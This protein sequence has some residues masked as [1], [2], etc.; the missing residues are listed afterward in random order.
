MK[1]IGMPI[2]IATAVLCAALQGC[3]DP[4]KVP[5][6]NG[7]APTAIPADG[8]TIAPVPVEPDP[9]NIDEPVAVK[10]IKPVKPVK[11]VKPAPAVKPVKPVAAPA[12]KPAAPLA[13]AP[14]ATT[15]VVKKGDM[16]SKI[17]KANKCR[18]EDIV[19]ANPGIRPDHIVPGQ[20][21]VIPAASAAPAKAAP[22]PA[23]KPAAAPA[24]K[25][26][27]PA[28]GAGEYVV[29]EGD[30]LSKIAKANGT[31]VGKIR[32]L[33]GLKGDMIRVGQKLKL[34][35]AGAAAAAPAPAAAAKP[36]DKNQAAAKP[37]EKPKKT[38]KPAPADAKPAEQPASKVDSVA[39]TV[40]EPPAD[41]GQY[42]LYTVLDGEDVFG[43]AVKFGVTT[44][45]IRSLNNLQDNTSLRA[46]QVLKLP[47]D[48]EAPG[49]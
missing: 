38:E 6:S 3:K 8:G 32:E 43:V 19:S 7:P 13:P 23:A 37:A 25:P 30:V 1:K 44:A 18:L 2:G 10:P 4:A 26:A 49:N 35:A 39:A 12:V 9:F 21:I 31:T 17:A 14:A 5:A 45:A 34:P 33:N 20:K 16:L 29:K 11:P 36:Q 15:Y 40:V 46:G 27:A 48:A 42:K 41:E 47:P 28:A 22:A 24:A